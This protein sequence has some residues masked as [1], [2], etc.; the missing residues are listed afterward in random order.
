M[1]GVSPVELACAL[2]PTSPPTLRSVGP[3]AQS[4]DPR[5]PAPVTI[6][7]DA[8]GA[9]CGLEPRELLVEAQPAPEN[10]SPKGATDHGS[11]NYLDNRTNGE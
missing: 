10:P 4:S 9:A 1:S 5:P 7:R 3:P 6:A 2:S 8:C 11:G